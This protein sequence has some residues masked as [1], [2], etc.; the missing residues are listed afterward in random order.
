MKDKIFDRIVLITAYVLT[1]TFAVICL[2][3]L[4]MAFC[5]SFTNENTL[6]REGY[7]LLIRHFDITS[8]K[9]IFTKT[10]TIYKA[11]L[12]TVSMTVL[13][14]MLTVFFT[15]LT[16]YP[17][18]V[19]G[20]KY[21]GKINLYIYL[22]MLLNGGLVPN[23][24]LI[25]R[26]L[27]LKDNF[28]VLIIPGM[29]NAYNIFLMTNYFKTLPA[30]LAESAKMDG[31]TDF[32]IFIRI[33]LPLSKPILAT[34]ALFAAMGYWNEWYKV[35]LYIEKPDL[36]TLQF[37]IMKLQRELDFLKSELGA[38][39]MEAMGNVTLPS[40][41]IRMATAMLSIGPI[42]LVYP[43]LQKYFM[44]GIMIGSVKE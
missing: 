20:L 38:R 14:T 44:K 24:I 27:D 33:I 15:A 23:Y 41:G 7:S 6:I 5:A 21:G 22:T 39:A 4:W 31:A 37:L 8:Y 9:I 42:V 34:I 35:L 29:I 32:K 43:F 13:G 40:L 3:P 11:Y 2:V 10:N 18:S 17:L 30:S 28:L 12:V 16:A 1:G 25:T 26:V 19:K 36:Y